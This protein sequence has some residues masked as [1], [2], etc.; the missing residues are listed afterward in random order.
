MAETKVQPQQL[1]SPYRFKAYRNAA[2]SP[3]TGGVVIVFDAESY[4]PNNNFNTSTGEYTVP[5]TG[6]YRI[7]ARLSV[8]ANARAFIDFVV[9]GVSK[10]RGSD[11]TSTAPACSV[12]SIETPLNAGDVI[13]I[14]F[15]LS[16]SGAL[17][18]DSNRSYF[19]GSL[20][21]S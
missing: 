20:A 10:E 18:T 12:L 11:L 4:D 2:L 17:E 8:N 15:Y 16:A 3:A 7:Y 19:M 21:T 9:N 13:R 6:I 5:V 1:S 14:S